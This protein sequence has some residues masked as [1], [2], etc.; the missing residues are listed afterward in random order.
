MAERV[1][2]VID[3]ADPMFAGQQA[4]YI[5]NRLEQTDGRKPDG[6]TNAGTRL[7][8]F[9]LGARQ[10]DPSQLPD[11]LRPFAA[12][13]QAELKAAERREFIFDRSGG[14]F[15]INN[16]PVD[17]EKAAA[18]VKT[19]RPQIWRLTNKSGGWWHPIHVHLEFM[20]VLTRNGAPPPANEADGMARKDT[21]L[22]RD[23]E[24]VDAFFKFRDF[25]GPFVFH[26][27][28]L[29]HEDMAMMAR[30]DVTR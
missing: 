10:A 25:T 15:T 20:R 2:V 11:T 29:E 5:E 16:E 26:C 28:N 22:L 17:I 4:L 18:I 21:I 1:E 14:V 9:V 30:F 6:L 24:T 19:N 12:I 8:K 13:G 23:N 3:F 7:L 27:H